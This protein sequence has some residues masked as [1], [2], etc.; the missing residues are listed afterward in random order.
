MAIVCQSM[1]QY[2][3]NPR[4][5]HQSYFYRIADAGDYL[6]ERSIT[7]K[8]PYVVNAGLMLNAEDVGLWFDDSD[9]HVTLTHRRG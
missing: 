8:K 3:Y 4:L 7:S 2:K 6:I 9:G 1:K 5:P